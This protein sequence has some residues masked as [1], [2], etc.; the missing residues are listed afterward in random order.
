[1]RPGVWPSSRDVQLSKCNR[2]V[3]LFVNTQLLILEQLVFRK[4]LLVHFHRVT[5][6]AYRD[7]INSIDPQ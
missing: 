5:S 6:F 2:V 3:K 7:V 4:T 1:M